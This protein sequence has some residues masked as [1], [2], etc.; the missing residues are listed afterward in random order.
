MKL[1]GSEQFA[2]RLL[3][4]AASKRFKSFSKSR[5]NIVPFV[6]YVDFLGAFAGGFVGLLGVLLGVLRVGSVP[7]IGEGG[8]TI[9]GVSRDFVYFP[10]FEIGVLGGVLGGVITM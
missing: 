8:G 6:Y 3:N 2:L 4:M 7:N 1:L 9:S 10:L 5:S